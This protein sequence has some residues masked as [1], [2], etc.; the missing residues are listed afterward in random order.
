[1]GTGG[2]G[3]GAP[4][5][6]PQGLYTPPRQVQGGR[7]LRGAVCGGSRRGRTRPWSNAPLGSGPESQETRLPKPSAHPENVAFP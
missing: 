6:A 3:P 2:G 5:L 4:R 7:G 1:M